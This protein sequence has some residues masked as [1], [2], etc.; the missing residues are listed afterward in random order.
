MLLTW[1]IK[2]DYHPTTSGPPQTR[3][4][5]WTCSCYYREKIE[6]YEGLVDLPQYA[7]IQ[8]IFSVTVCASLTNLTHY[9]MVP[10]MCILI[11]IFISS[12][13]FTRGDSESGA[14]ESDR[15]AQRAKGERDR[16]N[17][18][19]LCKQFNVMD[20][21]DSF[22][23]LGDEGSAARMKLTRILLEVYEA[24]YTWIKLQPCCYK[25][26]GIED[27]CNKRPVGAFSSI[28]SHLFTHPR[29]PATSGW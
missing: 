2:L 21:S 4:Y 10:I 9:F 27:V 13:P 7:H 25:P 24:L 1:I 23:E 16:A 19:T 12:P 29:N 26:D 20:W 8:S 15:V 6:N 14:S 28:F 5:I 3:H 18:Q 22:K 11:T 17:T